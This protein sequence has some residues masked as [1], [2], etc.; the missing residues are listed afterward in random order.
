[1]YG[2]VGTL[3]QARPG[4][5]YVW[6]HGGTREKTCGIVFYMNLVW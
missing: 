1:L 2:L 4:S 3:K 5:S 6:L